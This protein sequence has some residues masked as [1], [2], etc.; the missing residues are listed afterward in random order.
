MTKQETN[1]ANI[2]CRLVP[3][4]TKAS[5]NAI[6]HSRSCPKQP[7]N[8]HRFRENRIILINTV[9]KQ[10]CSLNT[11]SRSATNPC[12]YSLYWIWLVASYSSRTKKYLL[13]LTAVN[14]PN[15]PGFLNGGCCRTL[16]LSIEAGEHCPVYTHR[17]I[18]DC[19]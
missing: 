16:S 4:L 3:Y 8:L 18:I 15:A 9:N 5:N 19:S 17:H 6:V 14:P 11:V 1:D 2:S 10:R 7:F 12:P 13:C